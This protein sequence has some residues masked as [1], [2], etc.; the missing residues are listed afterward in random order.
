MDL[1]VCTVW[2]FVYVCVY[3]CFYLCLCVACVINK[4]PRFLKRQVL[5]EE[6]VWGFKQRL[7]PGHTDFPRGTFPTSAILGNQIGGLRR[8]RSSNDA[9]LARKSRIHCDTV[10]WVVP[11]RLPWRRASLTGSMMLLCLSLT[12]RKKVTEAALDNHRHDWSSTVLEIV[13]TA[14]KLRSASVAEVSR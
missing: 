3:V 4:F 13:S 2:L 12:K 14:G 5:A 10:V 11:T 7:K 8:T 9:G 6:Q 1:Y